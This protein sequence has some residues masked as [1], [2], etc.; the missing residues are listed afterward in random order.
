M[1]AGR[2][3]LLKVLS[4]L[5]PLPIGQNRASRPPQ[6]YSSGGGRGGA[7]RGRGR[8][9]VGSAARAWAPFSGAGSAGLHTGAHEVHVRHRLLLHR[10]DGDVQLHVSTLRGR[11]RRTVCARVCVCV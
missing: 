5:G 10:P 1:D 8:G 11:A 3:S 4:A 6:S 7:R 2:L 9:G